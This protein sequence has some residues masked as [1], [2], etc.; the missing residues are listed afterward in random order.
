M[1]CVHGRQISPAP[2]QRELTVR[3]SASRCSSFGDTMTVRSFADL[4]SL[5][6]K[7]AFVTG[8]G[9]GIGE[10][11]AARLAEA[12]ATVAVA[13]VE[14]AQA[15][16]V[17][18]QIRSLGRPAT[19]VQ[20]N[21]ADPAASKAAV[22]KVAERQGG[23]D[24]LVNNAGIFPFAPV[25]RVSVELWN[26]VIS[27]NLTGAFFLAQSAADRMSA[28]GRDGAILNIASV[29]A[30]RPTGNLVPYDASK[31]GMVMLTRSLALELAPKGIR[32]NAIAPGSIDTPGARA[33]TAAALPREVTSAEEL[34]RT[35]LARIPLGRMGTPDEIA[36]AALFLVSPAASYITGSIL[37]VDGGYL[38]A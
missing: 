13:D 25:G 34:A 35:F 20:C 29:D 3:I 33:A 1:D 7:S 27:V 23:V 11:I 21:V 22:A 36:T 12:G 24:I 28:S 8:G 18:D 6:G 15:Q 32:V 17:A 10:A 31:G 37:V 4:S 19:A 9:R 26:Q 16:R 14:G 5:E 30:F 38:I 2:R